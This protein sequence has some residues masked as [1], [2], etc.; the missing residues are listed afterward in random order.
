MIKILLDSAGLSGVIFSILVVDVSA[1]ME[2]S[3]NV[4]GLFSVPTAAYPWV[5][6]VMMSLMMPNVSFVGHLCGIVS[7]YLCMLFLIEGENTK[8]FSD[9]MRV[10]DDDRCSWSFQLDHPIE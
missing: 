7:G 10:F 4:L 3:Q 5:L 1:S 2:P 6:L 8:H 9:K